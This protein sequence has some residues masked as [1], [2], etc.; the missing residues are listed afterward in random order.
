MGRSRNKVYE[1][2]QRKNATTLLKQLAF[3]KKAHKT[4][5]TYQLGEEGFHPNERLW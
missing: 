5:S 1:P 4:K 2:T 3:H